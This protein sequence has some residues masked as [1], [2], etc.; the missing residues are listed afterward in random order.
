M[1]GLNAN[2]ILAVTLK[3]TLFGQTVLSTFHYRVLVGSVE[4]TYIPAAQAFADAFSA[5]VDN[6]TLA[7]LA[8]QSPQ[9]TLDSIRVQR[10]F[11]ARET[12]VDSPVGLPGTNANAC[13]ASN[14]AA[15]ISK[16]GPL[17]NPHNKGGVHIP[18]VSALNATAGVWDAPFLTLLN[19]VALRMRAIYNVPLSLSQSEMVIFNKGNPNISTTMVATTPQTTVRVSRRRTVGVGI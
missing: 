4:T 1:A 17:A 11:P 15:T 7:M 9:Y 5:G 3:G 8:A 16:R 18:G 6:P 14:V 10:L 2:D 19:E 12:Y 13:T